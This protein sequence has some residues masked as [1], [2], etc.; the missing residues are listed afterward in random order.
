MHSLLLGLVIGGTSIWLFYHLRYQSVRKRVLEL[1]NSLKEE[2]KRSQE[3]LQAEIDAA[4]R[5]SLDEIAKEKSTLLHKERQLKE[6]M[7]DLTAEIELQKKV[8]AKIESQKKDLLHKERSLEQLLVA[9]E[10]KLE[11]IGSLSMEEAKAAVMEKAETEASRLIENRTATLHTIHEKE[12]HRKAKE[13]IF[14]AIERKAQSLTKEFFLTKI[15][16]ENRSVIPSFIGK[17]GR[18]IHTLEELLN[19]KLIIEEDRLLISSHDARQRYTAQKVLEELLKQGKISLPRIKAVYDSVVQNIDTCVFNEGTLA[20]SEIDPTLSYPPEVV[21]ALGNLSLRSSSGQNVLKH[22]LE[23][24]E[25]MGIFAAELQLRPKIAKLMGIFH[26]IGKT[27]TTEYGDSHAAAGKT[28]L[29]QH[30][31]DEDIVNAVAAHH[32]ECVAKTEEA[33]LL[34]ICDRLSAQLPGIRS[35]IEPS[36]LQMV[37]QCEETAKRQP[38]VLSAWAHYAGSHVELIVRHKGQEKDLSLRHQLETELLSNPLPVNIT[39]LNINM[40]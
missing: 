26:D 2:S 1:T 22:S 24:A 28:F 33:R 13:L 7:Q 27:L 25:L 17:D 21:A 20:L 6:K 23:V 37:R 16:F 8:A 39:L 14:S 36:F 9:T 32:G 11:E 31:I 35:P 34:P 29:R 4:S 40:K 19:V 15:L 12:S 38:S 18:N 30:Q 3:K 10:K 5:K